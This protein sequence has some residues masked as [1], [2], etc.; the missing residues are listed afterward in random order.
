MIHKRYI[1]VLVFAVSVVLVAPS[2]AR[3]GFW[4]WLGWSSVA[5]AV[6]GALGAGVTVITAG[7]GAPVMAAALTQCGAGVAATTYRHLT[8]DS[9]FE[10]SSGEKKF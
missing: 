5:C 7:A 6:G 8:G 3:A 1:R 4:D 9:G 10:A 2:Y